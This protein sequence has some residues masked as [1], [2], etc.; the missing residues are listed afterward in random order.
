MPSSARAPNNTVQCGG[1]YLRL[2]IIEAL[3]QLTYTSIQATLIFKHNKLSEA[4]FLMLKS[5]KCT[6]KIYPD[7]VEKL[8][9]SLSEFV[10]LNLSI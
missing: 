4:K 6:I 7:E 3:L 1:Y 9:P 5:F 8:W 2:V 10:S